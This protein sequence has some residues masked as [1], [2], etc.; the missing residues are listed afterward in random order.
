MQTTDAC[1]GHGFLYH[2]QMFH[3]NDVGA[4]E[5]CNKHQDGNS[6]YLTE[7]QKVVFFFPPILVMIIVFQSECASPSILYVNCVFHFT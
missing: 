1:G 4:A 7:L 3:S 5:A 2:Q 6:L